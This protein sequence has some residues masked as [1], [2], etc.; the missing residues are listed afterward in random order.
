MTSV[1]AERVVAHPPERIYA[2]LAELDN[3]WRLGDAYLRL[4]SL[5]DDGRGARIGIR[6]PWGLRRTAHTEVT[7][8]VAPHRFGGTAAT[9]PGTSAHVCWTIEPRG[10]GA[11]VGLEARV[12]AASVVDRLLLAFGGR[13][14]LRRRFAHAVSRLGRALDRG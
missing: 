7:T 9:G 5:R 2:F 13:W 14:W 10:R 4:E 6:T 8:A 12:L 3:H 1:S 11:L